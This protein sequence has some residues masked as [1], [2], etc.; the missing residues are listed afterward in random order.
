MRGKRVVSFGSTGCNC[1]IF[2]LNR[3]LSISGELVS[4]WDPNVVVYTLRSCIRFHEQ[5]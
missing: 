3:R 4:L 1:S 2:R 5:L